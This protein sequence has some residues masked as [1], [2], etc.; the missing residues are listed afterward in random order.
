MVV[1][2]MTNRALLA[3]VAFSVVSSTSLVAQG[4]EPIRGISIAAFGTR[5]LAGVAA[6]LS[7][8]DVRTL[9]ADAVA[10]NV[11]WYQDDDQS[12]EIGPDDVK[13]ASLDS[14]GHCIDEAHRLGM[15]VMLKPMVDVRSRIWRGRIRPRDADA[16]FRSYTTFINTFADVAKRKKVEILCIATEMNTLEGLENEAR[17]RA[18]IREVRRR[19]DG[20]LTYAANW[21]EGPEAGG[22]YRAVRFWDALDLI[23]INPYFAI[24]DTTTPTSDQLHSGS[25]AWMDILET[26]REQNGLDKSVLYTEI[27]Y[28]SFD[29]G[30]MTPW[31]SDESG[32]TPDPDEQ[33]AA[34]EAFLSTAGEREWC[35]GLFL[36]RWEPYPHAGLRHPTGHTPQDKPGE[37]VIARFFGGTAPPPAPVRESLE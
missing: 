15:K 33:A 1:A 20:K 29:G 10:I 28:P 35:A 19:Y 27:G 22:G 16:W 18:A 6:D 11:S 9:G 17:W 24:A 5:V 31:G 37:K 3:V 25:R 14:V 26:W 30:A 32:L 34:L 36:W 7:L 21:H 23:G 2:A 12:T 13:S 8:A 4:S